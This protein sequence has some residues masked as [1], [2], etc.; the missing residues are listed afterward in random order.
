MCLRSVVLSAA[1]LILPLPLIADTVTTFTLNDVTFADGATATGTITIDVTTGVPTGVDMVYSDGAVTDD[2]IAAPSYFSNGPYSTINSFDPANE[3][4]NFS[5]PVSTLVGYTGGNICSDEPICAIGSAFVDF[6][7]INSLE[8]GSL[9]APSES[10]PA[11]PEPST[12]A[13]LGTGILGLAGAAHRR[14]PHQRKGV[15]TMSRRH[16]KRISA[17]SAI[18]LVMAALASKPAAAVPIVGLTLAAAAIQG[19]TPGLQRTKVQRADVSVPGREAVIAHVELAPGARAGLHTHPGEEM[20]YVMEGEAELLV[21][22][23]PA[24]MVK[25]GDAL[26]FRLE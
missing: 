18:A 25:A 26:S 19:Q 12:L 8:T 4:L 13:L 22:G 7:V 3:Y 15:L 9:D 14:R 17:L 23:Q 6:R 2:F 1:L 24:H 11:V 5:L 21:E 20:A 10:T 16:T